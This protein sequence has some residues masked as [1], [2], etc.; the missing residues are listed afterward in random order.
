MK[1]MRVM[2]FGT[3]GGSGVTRFLVDSAVEFK[4]RQNFEPFV[5]FRRKRNPLGQH[6][7][8]ELAA[9]G[10]PWSEVRASPKAI[11]IGQL[12]RRIRDFQPDVFV[13]HGHSDHIWGRMAAL[14][15]NV[16]VVVM[17][18]QCIERYIW[19]QR[20]RSVAL[21]RHT[22][23]IV[24]VSHGVGENLARLGYPR[25]K[26]HVIHNGTPLEKFNRAA[27]VPFDDR[28]PAVLMAARFARQ[29]DHRSLIRAAG[30]LRDRGSPVIVRLAGGGSSRHERKAR[31][32]VSE[33]G[34]S[35]QV[36]LLGPRDDMADLM[37]HHRVFVL[38]T[39]YEGMG[40][41]VAEAMAAGC[42][43]IASDVVG[44][45]E[46]IHHGE[47]GW[48]AKPDDPD[49]LARAI[50]EA[51]SPAGAKRAAAGKDWAVQ[52]LSMEKI[53]SGYES[54]FAEL[55]ADTRHSP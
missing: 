37:A 14:E 16:A 12:R 21:A 42:A 40:I 46:L 6:F 34:L 28:E 3:G 19:L 39:H 4:R 53:A 2:L 5:V 15:E 23:A 45:Q 24:A 10:V 55:L 41:A 22:D 43:V 35:E 44:V 8:A 11:T 18:E 9:A 49:S 48:L 51:L 29:K 25:D 38:S 26:L 36:E 31:R 30:L 7:I 13:A 32:L 17:V 1:P 33:L 20:F 52:N 50:Q 47:T 27:E 54:L